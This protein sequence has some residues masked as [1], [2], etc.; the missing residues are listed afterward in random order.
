MSFD[1]FF[2][3]FFSSLSP[4][5]FFFFFF[6]DVRDAKPPKEPMA[7]GAAAALSLFF[8]FFSSTTATR[9]P[10][11]VGTVSQPSSVFSETPAFSRF[12]LERG[13]RP[14]LM[15]ASRWMSSW[16]SAIVFACST[17]RRG[18]QRSSRSSHKS[19]TMKRMRLSNFWFTASFLSCLK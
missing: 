16:I 5:S 10:P 8:G 6:S 11:A 15:S 4:L 19:L 17:A 9:R 18:F 12:T 7:L 14:A 1:D 2:F 13:L 3:F